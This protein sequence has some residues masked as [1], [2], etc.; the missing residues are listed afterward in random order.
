M[1]N[2]ILSFFC[3]FFLSSCVIFK[4][5]K[6]Y[7]ITDFPVK[8][9]LESFTKEPVIKKVENDFLVTDE[10]ILNSSLLFDYYR[11]IEKWKEK[12]AVN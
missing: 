3:L 1:Q 12:H 11:R 4:N 10:M 2:T 9:P 5:K 6:D 7:N 8:P